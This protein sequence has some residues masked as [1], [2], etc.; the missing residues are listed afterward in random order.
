MITATALIAAGATV[1]AISILDSLWT[2]KHPT[3][4]LWR[5]HELGRKVP[6]VGLCLFVA[7]L[8]IRILA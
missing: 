6:I 2:R 8:I 1:I 5:Y 7:G 3:R 4:P